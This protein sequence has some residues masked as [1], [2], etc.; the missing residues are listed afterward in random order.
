MGRPALRLGRTPCPGDRRATVRAPVRAQEQAQAGRDDG[1]GLDRRAHVHAEAAPDPRPVASLL[2]ALACRGRGQA[3]ARSRFSKWIE[4][5]T[6]A[7]RFVRT[8]A[9]G[10]RGRLSRFRAAAPGEP[11]CVRGQHDLAGRR[12]EYSWCFDWR[13]TQWWS[14]EISSPVNQGLPIPG[15]AG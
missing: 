13:A 1:R 15:W 12:L 4:P 5:S 2:S 14:F 11:P 10:G 3:I 7:G 9:A 8:P 6:R